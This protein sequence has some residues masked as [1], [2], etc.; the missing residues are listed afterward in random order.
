MPGRASGPQAGNRHPITLGGLACK[1]NLSPARWAL[2]LRDSRIRQCHPL[3]LA[4]SSGEIDENQLVETLAHALDCPV[5]RHPPA[6]S[7]SET[8]GASF[9]RRGYRAVFEGRLCQV[10]APNGALVDWLLDRHIRDCLPPVVLTTEQSLLDAL[11]LAHAAA[12]AEAAATS[13]PPRFTA[14]GINPAGLVIACLA[15]AIPS[16]AMLLPISS[17]PVQ[18]VAAMLLCLTPVFLVALLALLTAVIVSGEPRSLPEPLA[19]T[20][21]PVYTLLVPLRQEARILDALIARLNQLDYPPERRQVLLI[22][23]E[24]DLEMRRAF[25]RRRLPPGFFRLVVPPGQPRTKPR[26]LNA[27]LCF[28]RGS[29]V[30]VYDAEDA[31]EPAQLRMAAEIFAAAPATVICLQ[32]RLAISNVSDHMLT[33][34]FAQDY[35]TLF[36][37][38]KSG[39]AEAG[40]PVALG[41]TSNHF[42]AE[43][44]LALGGWDAWNVTEDAD[45]GY[46]IA[47]AGFR[48]ADLPSTTWEEAPNTFRVWRNQRIRWLKGWYQTCLVHARHIPA[49]WRKLDPLGF[50][51]AL[52]VPFSLL[53]SVLLMPL[54]WGLCLSRCFGTLPFMGNGLWQTLLDTNMLLLMTMGV[55]A[56]LVPN[57]VALRR[58]GWLRLWPWLAWLPVTHLCNSVAA[59]MALWELLRRP[60]HWRKTPHGLARRRMPAVR[61]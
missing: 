9:R 6:P 34:R 15:I 22:I 40:W 21:L 5:R 14:R 39:F 33:R 47:L 8:A 28:A 49:Y 26:A 11:A 38:V 24:D 48:V 10:I 52:A 32:A 50:M 60:Q 57:V 20:A 35:A 61:C 58:R 29:L 51:V 44:L 59:W 31:P 37:C 19:D 30:T 16:L 36:D 3:D 4:V 23:E 54:F 13:V 27:G 2:L 17:P 45:L 56:D 42:R 46:R 25:A 7:G 41:G 18:L 43:A 55:I 53:T 12:L 1:L